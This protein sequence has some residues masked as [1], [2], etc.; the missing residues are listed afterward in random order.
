M[1]PE[2]GEDAAEVMADGG[3][4]DVGGIASAA[5]EI[6]SAE[7]AFGLQVADHG[8]DGRSASQLALDHSEDAALLAGDEEPAWPA[9]THILAISMQPT[10]RIATLTQ[11]YPFF[12]DDSFDSASQSGA[13]TLTKSAR[14]DVCN[15]R[16]LVPTKFGL[17]RRIV[18]GGLPVF[19]N[20]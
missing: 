17:A 1:S 13:L 6:A 10:T 3:E 15:Q 9:R 18:A 16:Q 14:A 12:T 8:L 7:V 20:D 19:R 11:T 4:A 2:P 5:L